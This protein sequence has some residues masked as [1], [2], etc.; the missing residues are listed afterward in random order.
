MSS[1]LPEGIQLVEYFQECSAKG[2]SLS[3][4]ARQSVGNKFGGKHLMSNSIM[5]V[6]IL[7]VSLYW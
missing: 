3:D 2:G 5:V 7:P 6:V 4:A 1:M